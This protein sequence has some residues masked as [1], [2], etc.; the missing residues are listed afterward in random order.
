[1]V[2]AYASPLTIRPRLLCPHHPRRILPSL[3]LA[4]IHISTRWVQSGSKIKSEMVTASSSSN[5]GAFTTLKERVTFAQEIKKSK[6]MAIAGPIFD[7][8]AANAF[9]SEVIP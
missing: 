4:G 6:F 9:L 2:V 5:D 8:R 1:M 7:Q 3:S